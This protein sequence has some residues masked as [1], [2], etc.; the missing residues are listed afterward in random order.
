MAAWE[1]LK[2]QQGF[3][4]WWDLK[5]FS[6]LTDPSQGG[7]WRG[8]LTGSHTLNGQCFCVLLLW[9]FSICFTQVSCLHNQHVHRV[10][11]RRV[12]MRVKGVK[13]ENQQNKVVY[14][15]LYVY[16]VFWNIHKYSSCH[17]KLSLYRK[18][19]AFYKLPVFV[20]MLWVYGGNRFMFVW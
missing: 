10:T 13:Q 12:W 8:K 18:S 17:K 11:G 20:L 5:A 15:H 6:T 9:H 14:P 3:R 7:T 1:Q 19:L 2:E 16:Y 4:V